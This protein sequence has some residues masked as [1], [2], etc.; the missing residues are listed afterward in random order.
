[1]ITADQINEFKDELTCLIN[2][3][4]IDVEI[5]TPDYIVAEHLMESIKVYNQATKERDKWFGF[6][7]DINP[8][9]S[10]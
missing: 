6:N 2:K 10:L 9:I 4:G 7:P 3:H 5:S 8:P 1:M